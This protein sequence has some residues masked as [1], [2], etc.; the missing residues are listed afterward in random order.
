MRGGDPALGGGE[1]VAWG[2][3]FGRDLLVSYSGISE[4]L[5]GIHRLLWRDTR[6]DP[7]SAGA[8]GEPGRDPLAGCWRD[9]LTSYC[10]ANVQMELKKCT[11]NKDKGGAQSDFFCTWIKRLASTAPAPN[12]PP[13]PKKKEDWEK[14]ER[15][16]SG[17]GL[18]LGLPILAF[19][20]QF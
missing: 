18:D 10:P 9:P 4:I 17:A 19:P 1:L 16:E 14:K 20:G 3:T 13:P 8:T 11:R 7:A 5:G 6:R 12:P 15:K 2:R